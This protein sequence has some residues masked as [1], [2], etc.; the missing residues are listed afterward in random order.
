MLFRTILFLVLAVAVTAVQT[1]AQATGAPGR[2]SQST[3]ADKRRTEPKSVVVPMSLALFLNAFKEL[4]VDEEATQI[5]RGL[6]R[7]LPAIYEINRRDLDR[8]GRAGKTERSAIID[9]TVAAIRK[10]AGETE[11]WAIDLGK[12]LGEAIGQSYKIALAEGKTDRRPFAENIVAAAALLESPP[13]GVPEDLLTE[14]RALVEIASESPD[15]LKSIS[16]FLERS[17]KYLDYLT[18]RLD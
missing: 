3:N 15:S 1:S 9:R 6:A 4:P 13:P 7:E 10:D 17:L 11:G 5:L 8:F 14:T 2:G 18:K 12:Q 16:A